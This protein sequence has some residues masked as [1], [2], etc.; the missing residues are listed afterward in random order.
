[1]IAIQLSRKNKSA[2]F[3]YLI[4]LSKFMELLS[5]LRFK[6]DRREMEDESPKDVDNQNLINF[7]GGSIKGEMKEGSEKENQQIS[8]ILNILTKQ[9]C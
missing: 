4:F 5:N 1:M 6:I 8:E 2:N 7:I 3:Y 9:G